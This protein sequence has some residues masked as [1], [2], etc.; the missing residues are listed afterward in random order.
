MTTVRGG[1]WRIILLA[2]AGGAGG[3]LCLGLAAATAGYAL[4]EPA[5]HTTGADAR[6]PQDLTAIFVLSVGMVLVAAILLVAMAAALR[7][8]RGQAEPSFDPRP[9]RWW[10]VIVWLGVWLAS[11]V[12]AQVLHEH[13]VGHPIVPILHVAAIACPIYVLIRVAVAGIRDGSRLRLWGSLSTGMLLGTGLAATIEITL[14][15]LAGIVG[16][17]YLIANPEQIQIMQ[18]LVLR[19]SHAGGPEETL[20][21]L[22]PIMASPIALLAALAAVAVASPLVEEIAKSVPVW[23]MNQRASTGARG[24]WAGA[25]SGAGFALLEGLMVSANAGDGAASMLMLRA[26]SSLMHVVASGLA[27]WGIGAFRASRRFSRLA[28]GYLAAMGIH[29]LWNTAVVVIAYGALRTT[30]SA[31]RPDAP[32]LA[33]SIG[34]AMLLVMLLAL[35]PVGLIALN[36]RFRND[37]RRQLTTGPGA[38]PMQPPGAIA[39]NGGAQ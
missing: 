25:L 1:D 37:D 22:G 24:F 17:V 28:L 16:G 23:A 31:A 14:L 36:L 30:Y 34:G 26:G 27:G 11:S 32:G 20:A 21:L 3:I 13:D 38:S 5:L 15:M 18:R 33:L 35:L 10:S 39:K 12:L 4:A 2:L 19:L 29:A 8:I 9:M 7:A 6:G